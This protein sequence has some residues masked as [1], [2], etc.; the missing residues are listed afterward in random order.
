MFQPSHLEWFEACDQAIDV[1]SF[2]FLDHG[3]YAVERTGEV[4]L[5]DRATL[6]SLLRQRLGGTNDEL[7][8][9]SV[10]GA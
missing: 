6:L 3:V 8:G 4:S 2:H 9:G 10:A 1:V 7:G 5:V